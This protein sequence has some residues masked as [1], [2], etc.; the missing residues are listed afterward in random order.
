MLITGA[1]GFLGL[2]TARELLLR[3]H[4]LRV[5]TRNARRARASFPFPAQFVE[6]DL[7]EDMLPETALEGVDAVL[8][9]AGEPVAGARW[10]LEQKRR[11][12][13]SRVLGTRHF[14]QGVAQAKAKNKALPLKAVV[15]GSA[16]GFYGNRGDEQLTESSAAGDG[17]LAEV[18]RQWENEI[19]RPGFDE[20]RQVA[21]RTG[22]V[23]GLGG[24]ALDKLLPIFRKGAG[25]ALG[26][27][28]QWL[29]WI[30]LAD[31]IAI[32]VE[33]LEN[34]SYRGV[35]NGV[36]PHPVTNR[37]F[38]RDLA[39]VLHRPALLHAPS[40][41][42]RLAMGEMSHAVLDS[43]RVQPEKISRLGFKFRFPELV[44]ALTDL[45]APQGEPSD[46]QLVVDQWIPKPVEEIFPFFSDAKNLKELTP[47]WIGFE[48]KNV[49]DAQM[50]TGT[51]I[52]YRLKVHGFSMTWRTRI[53]E[54]LPNQ[55]FVDRQLKG[56]YAK[57]H[58]THSFTGLRGGT[59]MRDRVIYRLPLG[60]LGKTFALWKVRRDVDAVFA[61][62]RK[63]IGEIFT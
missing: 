23:L 55:A 3:G 29:S 18:C 16:I 4:E 27:G 12:R 54:W 26:S 46:Q 38:T 53:E 32:F 60:A 20:V 57:W 40:L 52:D 41:A 19:F 49:S 37:E 13:D 44:E 21:V 7:M 31:L 1:T 15:A 62:R 22:V 59:L 30:H 42:I 6:C 24:G 35:I 51:L 28:L 17:F 47:P 14:W 48:V 8:H 36:S 34:D 10:T 45:C 58:H 43:Q 39:R 50:A 11:I 25:G 9:L 56:P 63:R 33:A 2:A 61:Y 5:V